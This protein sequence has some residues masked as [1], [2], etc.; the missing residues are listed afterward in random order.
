MKKAL[1][2][3]DTGQVFAS[4]RRV[5]IGKQAPA[6]YPALF[7]GGAEPRLRRTRDNLVASVEVTKDRAAIVASYPVMG[8]AS[9]AQL[10]PPA[11]WL[12]VVERNI[13]PQKA[14][15]R[16][17]MWALV[18]QRSGL[19]AT[20]A[21]LLWLFFH[22][23][24]TRRVDRLVT[25]AHRFAAR[26]WEA[27][28]GLSGSDELAVVG[29]AFDQMGER[30]RATQTQLEESEAQIRLLLDSV[31]EG[32][33]GL[34]LDGRSTLVNRSAAR[35]LG[36]SDARELLGVD[37]H[38]TW[39]YARADGTAYPP[40]ECPILQS[41]SVGTATH[42]E[43]DFLW[44]KDGTRLAVELWSYPIHQRGRHIGAV[45][46][47]VDTT[48]RQRA[49]EAQRFLIDVSTQL[50]E[51]LDEKRAV[52][53]VARLAIPQLGQ[54]CVIDRV[55]DEGVLRRAAEVH[56]DP[57]RQ[58]LLRAL[59]QHFALGG[60]AL[61]PT[62]RVLRTGRP[63]LGDEATQALLDTD[64][65]STEYLELL[66]RLGTRTAIALPITVR[67]QTLAAMLLVSDTP[68][69]QYGP[70]ELSLAEE[71]TR[72]ASVAMDN[73]RLYQQSQEA[74]RLRE[75]FLSVASHEL[76][77]PLTPLRLQ[78]QTIQRALGATGHAEVPA[79]LLSKVEKALG[80]V[81]R[82]SQLVDGLLDV[83][84]LSAGRLRLHLE[85]VDMVALTRE[86][87]E[88]FADQ[89]SVVG[90]QLIVTTD[91]PTV[92]HWDR[93]RLEQ[94]FTNLITNALKYGMGKPVE[95]HV[96]SS[97]GQA[98][99]SIRDHGIGIAAQDQERIFGRFERAVPSRQYGGLGLGLYIARS[100]V[101]ALGGNIH[102]E[103][104]PGAGALFTVDLPLEPAR[105]VRGP[106]APVSD[107]TDA[108]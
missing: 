5:E 14:Q 21:G 46:T 102:V 15:A 49:E 66:R 85:E 38:A 36:Y 57:A 6:L 71:L 88:R 29:R 23:A 92:G 74:V 47:F 7:L 79:H 52:E 64:P 65:T 82:L 99:W 81:K 67:G 10:A 72:R 96:T 2:I 84:S 28:S 87:A 83:S 20:L 98:R 91:G 51:L 56:Q 13:S 37:A 34:D 55:D 104:Q 12:L 24:L 9:P 50:A 25:T 32:I 70:L 62:A 44:R 42:V 40:S 106:E 75:D 16:A 108:P 103:S 76:N 17:Q 77:T 95:L 35:M 68:G 4:I 69:F 1:L 78:L 94:V 80:Q 105:Y 19:L 63:L 53:R 18:V 33:Y 101:H 54:W 31:A 43:R 107:T 73:A 61:L 100:I 8:P 58:E 39:H 41:L 30:L 86:L 3:D 97:G 59:S 89:A 27:R 90:C 60:R 22:F 26:D 11:A 45:A 48:A 93:T